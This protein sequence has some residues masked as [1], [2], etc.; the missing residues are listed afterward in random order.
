[1]TD[2]V[3]HSALVDV[4]FGGNNKMKGKIDYW[5]GRPGRVRVP[6]RQRVPLRNE[7]RVIFMRAPPRLIRKRFETVSNLQ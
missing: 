7:R 6:P 3:T 2:P 4:C 1:M 5:S